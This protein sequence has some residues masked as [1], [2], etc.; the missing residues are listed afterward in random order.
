VRI[1]AVL[2]AGLLIASTALAGAPDRELECTK[3]KKKILSIQSK[4]RAGYT[5]AQGEKLQAE[6]RRLRALRRKACR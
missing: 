5:R 2:I 4:M 1:R 3:I 6:L